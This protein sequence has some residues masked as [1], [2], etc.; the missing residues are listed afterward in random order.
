MNVRHPGDSPAQGAAP[1]SAGAAARGLPGRLAGG[2]AAGLLANAI[3][4]RKMRK[5]ASAAA[6]LGGAAAIGGLAWRAYNRYRGGAT[7]QPGVSARSVPI[8]WQNLTE[9]H[10]TP[11]EADAVEARELL[12][13][14]AITA[15][16]NADG[17][18]DRRER[19]L[20]LSRIEAMN[21]SARDKAFLA[22]EIESPMSYEELAGFA[23]TPELA[24]EIYTASL[25]PLDTESLE[26]RAYLGALAQSMGLPGSLVRELDRN[27]EMLNADSGSAAVA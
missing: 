4:G 21:V 1:G 6:R 2:L 23:R 5:F 27:A 8:S 11:V 19:L 15:A 12:I 20:I 7:P 17:L 24:A 14:R 16:A 3:G 26:S 25:I 10:F 18:I 22:D 13:L 9:E